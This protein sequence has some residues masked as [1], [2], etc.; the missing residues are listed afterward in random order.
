MFGV[1]G[2]P[3]VMMRMFTVSDGAAARKSAGRAI[4]LFAVAACGG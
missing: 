1:A 3:H 2:L 4:P